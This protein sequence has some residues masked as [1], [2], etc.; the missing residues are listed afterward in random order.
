MSAD[1]LSLS[2]GTPSWSTE[3]CCEQPTHNPAD[4]RFSPAADILVGY[5]AA[6]STQAGNP[7][8]SMTYG[9]TYDPTIVGGLRLAVLIYQSLGDAGEPHWSVRASVGHT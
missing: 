2:G 6:D 3:I 4:D 7:L 5:V 1:A 9:G 8:A